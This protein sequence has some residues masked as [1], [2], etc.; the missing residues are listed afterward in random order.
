VAKYRDDKTNNA[1]QKLT[2]VTDEIRH[3]RFGSALTKVERA[4]AAQYLPDPYDS[5]EAMLRKSRGLSDLISL[6]NSRLKA[7][8]AEAE[9][10]DLVDTGGPRPTSPSGASPIPGAAG[11]SVT[12]KP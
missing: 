3:G 4:S 8:G 12:T 9:T 1:I 10:G 2:F 6:N 11:W 5:R 7:K